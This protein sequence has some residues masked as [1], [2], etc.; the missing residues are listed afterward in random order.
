MANQQLV[1]MLDK[2]ME[3]MREQKQ[4][5]KELQT[6]YEEQKENIQQLQSRYNKLSKYCDQVRDEQ[7]WYFYYSQELRTF[8]ISNRK[9]INNDDEINKIILKHYII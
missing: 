2:C 1:D 4:T 9:S 5:Y 6:K 3:I 7:M 8:I